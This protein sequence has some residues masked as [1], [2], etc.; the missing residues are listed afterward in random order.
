[1]GTTTYTSNQPVYTGGV[2]YE[3]GQPFVMDDKEPVSEAWQAISP[4]EKAAAVA[5][6]PRQHADVNLDT[7]SVEGLKAHAASLGIDIGTAKSK[8]DIKAVI[9]AADDPLR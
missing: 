1:M 5:V 3:P 6:D 8:D 9:R 2:Y 7:L 4:T